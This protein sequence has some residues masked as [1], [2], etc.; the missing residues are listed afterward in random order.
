MQ[1]MRDLLELWS[2][3]AA[4][5][6]APGR[7]LRLPAA[8]GEPAG[9]GLHPVPTVVAALRGAVRVEVPGGR[10]VDLAAGDV[11]AIAAGA[12]H[13]H[14][15][16]RAG[17][18]VLELGFDYGWCD[19]ELRARDVAISAAMP[20]QPA[21]GLVGRMLAGDAAAVGPLLEQVLER[22]LQDLHRLPPAARRMRD[23]IRSH[24][25]TP[26]TAAAVVR[27]S[28]LRP[29]R[30]WQVFRLHFG[31]T[32]H[33]ALERRRCAVAR[34]LLQRGADVSTAALRCGYR[35]RGTF[36][37]AYARVHGQPPGGR[38]GRRA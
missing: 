34:S 38:R 8:G 24:G 5:A 16:L 31:C 4:V 3:V 26:I 2:A 36:A 1:S 18:A 33:Q 15:P 19:L 25:L 13:R 17:A 10:P 28:G 12:A 29:S 9:H 22:P 37:R 32:P 27:A 21:E 23:R 30:A 35:D 20:R 11:L 7:L 6:R 14:A